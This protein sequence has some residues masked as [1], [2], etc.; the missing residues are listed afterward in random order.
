MA[1]EVQQAFLPRRY[2]VFPRGVAPD[3]SAWRFCHRYLPASSLAG[4]FFEVLPLSPSSA[5]VFI[6]DVMGHGVRTALVMAVIR[7]LVDELQDDAGDPSR[8]LREI[9]QA[10]LAHWDVAQTTVFASA[11]YLTV[12]ASNGQVQCALAG[13][14]SPIWLRRG[15]GQAEFLW[16]HDLRQGPVLGLLPDATYP[17]IQS[18]L[19][20]GDGVL[21]YTDGLYEVESP[22][23]ESFGQ[24]RLRGLVQQELAL[25]CDQL[26]ERLLAEAQH[27]SATGELSDDVCLVGVHYAH[28]LDAGS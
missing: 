27:F 11:C 8:F 14:P 19:A 16:R 13:H 18:E 24:E 25:R 2:P 6:C 28:R 10:L 21:L 7:G 4:D 5:G 22:A 23:G 1:R 12:D 26:Q 9:N 20:V 3:Q 17:M 15:A